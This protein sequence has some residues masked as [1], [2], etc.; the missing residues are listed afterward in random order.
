M[1]IFRI[2]I[3]ISVVIAGWLVGGHILYAADLTGSW[4]SDERACDK[5]FVK[6]NGKIAIAKD[7]DLYGSGLIIEQNRITGKNA[8]Y[9]IIS[10]KQDG[11]ITNFV[12]K[13]ATGV[14][15]EN[16][17]LGL[18][19]DNENKITR[20]YTDLPELSVSYFRCPL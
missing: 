10:R 12:M 19:I 15:L 20:L 4:A 18:K 6:S 8:A 3:A 9:D 1:S 2:L 11:P 17:K 5:V 16:V 7:A 14:A 13:C